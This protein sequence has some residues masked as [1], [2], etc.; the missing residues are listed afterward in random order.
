M[1]TASVADDSLAIAPVYLE[2]SVCGLNRVLVTTEQGE[3]VTGIFVD[4]VK[5]QEVAEVI[6]RGRAQ[7]FER[8]YVGIFIER[9]KCKKA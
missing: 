3:Q 9:H 5:D 2:H 8:G 1:Q 4:L 7:A 6:A